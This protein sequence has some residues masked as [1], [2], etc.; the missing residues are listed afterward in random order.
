[1]VIAR[2]RLSLRPARKSDRQRIANLIHFEAYVHRHLDWR[3]PL[4]WVGYQPYIVAEHDEKVEAALACPPDP[5]NVAW[6]RLFAVSANLRVEE[7]WNALWD[8]ARSYLSRQNRIKVAAI[9]LQNWF[10]AL[11]EGS[12]FE[13]IYDVVMLKWE[14]GKIP[15]VPSIDPRLGD[16]N[17]RLMNY[18]DLADVHDLD[19]DSFGP[20]W[21]N[22]L[23]LLKVAFEQTAVATVAEDEKGILGYQISTNSPLGGHL[24]RLAVHP[25]AQ[26]KGIGY[27]LV[28]DMLVQFKRRGA[29]QVTVN[30]Q[31]DNEPSLALYEKAGFSNTGETYPVYQKSFT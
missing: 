4:D 21:H 3:P 24:A 25:R 20:V 17:I 29:Q 7:A 19:E 22:S 16:V 10:R 15:K 5:P 28:R 11:L 13:H 8:K 6:I 23:E 14:G 2:E 30:T 31:A 1:M 12:E 26:G 9:P 27:W 18:D